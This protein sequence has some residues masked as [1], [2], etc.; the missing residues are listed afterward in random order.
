MRKSGKKRG[1]SEMAERKDK[2]H[3]GKRNGGNRRK[4]TEENKRKTGKI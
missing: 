1:K 3:R 2:Q 4:T